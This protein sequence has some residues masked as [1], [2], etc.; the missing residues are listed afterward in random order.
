[1]LRAATELLVQ[2]GPRAVT[3]D[4]VS[5]TSGVAKSTLY[6]HWSSRTELLIDV[7][8]CSSHQL[9]EPDLAVG[10]EPA[11]RTYLAS[12]ASN[13]ADPNWVRIFPSV[14]SLRTSIPELEAFFVADVAEKKRSM[15][16][17]LRLGVSEGV[18]P[19]TVDFDDAASMLIAP[20]IFAAL[21]RPAGANDEGEL[22]G[23]AGRIVDRFSASYRSD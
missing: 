9:E 13:F 15:D 3:V 19:D 21:T 16:E 6:R 7:I 8:R 2:S 5:E 10:F 1:M 22:A 17:I 4:A 14:A 12:A 11:L 23:L 18:I 20:F